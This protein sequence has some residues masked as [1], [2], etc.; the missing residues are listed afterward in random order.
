M[1]STA[2]YILLDFGRS[3]SAESQIDFMVFQ[4]PYLI[5]KNKKIYEIKSIY[6]IYEQVKN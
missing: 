6:I 4:A 5:I 3:Y 2:F 1:H